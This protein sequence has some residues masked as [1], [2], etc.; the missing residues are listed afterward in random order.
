MH[1]RVGELI[2]LAVMSF[3]NKDE[4]M[5]NEMNHYHERTP[6]ILSQYVQ[7]ITIGP[8]LNITSI[9]IIIEAGKIR[10][11]DNVFV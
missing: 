9:I 10:L 3:K 11:K 1:A 5:K 8:M 7:H 6:I 4:R 2:N